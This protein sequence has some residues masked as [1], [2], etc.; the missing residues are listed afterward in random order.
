MRNILYQ[1][2]SYYPLNSEK[3]FRKPKSR[4][5]FSTKH[6][7]LCIETVLEMNS[8]VCDV[9][10]AGNILDIGQT[11]CGKTNLVQNLTMNNMFGP[12]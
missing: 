11:G 12:L 8:Y 2:F 5:Q 9:K 10:F 3:K 7:K 6:E 4:Y 1:N